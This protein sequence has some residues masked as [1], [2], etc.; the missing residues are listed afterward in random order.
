MMAML[1]TPELY[2]H[3]PA[4]SFLLIFFRT[5]YKLRHICFSGGKEMAIPEKDFMY[6]EELIRKVDGYLLPQQ[7][8]DEMSYLYSKELRDSLYGTHPK[9]F[10]KIKGIGRE[11]PTL[12]PIC[13]RH[14]H[15]D[16]KVIA[17]ARKVVEK[18]MNDKAGMYDSNELTVILG[19]LD[20]LHNVYSKDIPKPPE[21]AGR[22]AN[23]TRMMNRIKKHLD[24]YKGF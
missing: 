6:L 23:V 12:L 22:K 15:K 11:F 17:I 18:I 14:G 2:F 1:A 8:D 4:P 16:P 7:D 10:L 13:N 24:V 3:P 21:A 20:R 19:K 5:K 9:C